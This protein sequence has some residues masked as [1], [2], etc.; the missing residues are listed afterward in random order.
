M[1][2]TP[3]NAAPHRF[4]WFYQLLGLYD[5]TS[6]PMA[7]FYDELEGMSPQEIE[8]RRLMG[9]RQFTLGPDRRRKYEVFEEMD[10]SGLVGAILD[11]Y[12]EE[13]TQRDF[14]RDKTVWVESKAPHIRKA[15]EEAFTNCQVEDRSTALVRKMAKLG[16]DFRRLLYETGRGVLGWAPTRAVDVDRVEDKYARLVGFQE[17]GLTYRDKKRD[18]SWPWDYIHFRLLGKDEHSGYGTSLLESM[19][20]PWRRMML[21]E[22][23]ILMYRLRRMPDRNM[24]MV[25]V[26]NMEEHEA[27]AYVNQWRQRFRKT[28]VVDPA[29]PDFR[30]QYNPL[31]PLED[32]FVPLIEGRES[33]VETLAG[34]GNIGE[35]YDLDHFRDAFFGSAKSPKAYFG[36]EGDVNAKATLI[37]QDVRFARGIKRLQ[38][39]YLFGLRQLGDVHLTLLR[40]ETNGAKFDVTRA[41]NAYVLQMAPISFLDEAARLDLMK[42]RMELVEVMS[43]LATDMQLDPRA[44][45]TYLLLNYAKLP[46]D[47][48][49][50][51]IKKTPDAPGGAAPAPAFGGGEPFERLTPAQQAAV[52]DNDGRQSA[53]YY[54]LSEAEQIAIARCVHDSPKLRQLIGD[55]ADVWSEPTLAERAALQQ[56]P[57]LLPPVG[58]RLE[59][60]ISNTP[61]ALQLAEDLR[62]NAAA[63]A[64]KART[65]ES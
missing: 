43:R 6:R 21:T 23:S 40:D 4:S 18:V 39:A 48:V 2:D 13:A 8:A 12:A 57:A 54:S 59:D 19:F 51:L 32:I 44:W 24:I 42:M 17:K 50:K 35:I 10:A 11:V 22:E 60:S 20:A 9:E 31:T 62:E 56:D 1:A 58:L 63:A 30:K 5:R 45:S 3:P 27:M 52:L 55:F 26:G 34:G 64:K 46:E 28:M 29:S 36:F 15:I 33:R 47:M 16:D 49:L 61:A 7:S 25:N 14:D 65:L 37:T 41:E 38:R 53:G